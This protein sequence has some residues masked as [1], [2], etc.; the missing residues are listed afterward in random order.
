MGP[1]RT[2]GK[3]TDWLTAGE[4]KQPRGH[5]MPPSTDH[6]LHARCQTFRVQSPRPERCQACCKWPDRVDEKSSREKKKS[7][8]VGFCRSNCGRILNVSATSVCVRKI[9]R[10]QLV[11]WRARCGLCGLLTAWLGSAGSRRLMCGGK[12]GSGECKQRSV[13]GPL[14]SGHDWSPGGLRMWTC[15]IRTVNYNFTQNVT[16]KK[17][18]PRSFPILWS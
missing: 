13:A 4:I 18:G 10:R 16:Q 5:T 17:T 3:E 1:R 11:A 2:G 6:S 15:N 8:A 7:D 12:I 9:R 14:C